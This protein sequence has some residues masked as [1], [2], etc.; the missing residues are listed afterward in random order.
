MS[1]GWLKDVSEGAGGSGTEIHM[2]PL[3]D[4]RGT[5]E[6]WAAESRSGSPERNERNNYKVRNE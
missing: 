5:E 2:L 4:E 3:A 6:C 1:V